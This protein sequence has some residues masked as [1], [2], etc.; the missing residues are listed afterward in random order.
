MP[1]ARYYSDGKLDWRKVVIEI[2]PGS[3]FIHMTENPTKPGEFLIHR[4][5]HSSR[6]GDGVFSPPICTSTMGTDFPDPA[7]MIAIGNTYTRA[8][9][10]CLVPGQLNRDIAMMI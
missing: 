1:P 9:R 4:V 5:S 10:Q 8:T 6:E 7:L 3:M 2:G